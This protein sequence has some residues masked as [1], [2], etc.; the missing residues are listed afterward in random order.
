[1]QLTGKHEIPATAKRIWD[2]MM[3]PEVL[4]RITPG[5][6]HLELVEEDS[7]KAIAEIKIGPVGGAF[8]GTLKV[9]DKNEPHSFSLIVQQNSRLGTASAVVAMALNT[10]ETGTTEVSF[11]G[12]VRLSGMMATMGQRVLSPVAHMLS[13]QF[14]EALKLEV[15]GSV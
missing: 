3:D 10:L 14:F 6:T 11:L 9:A 7:Y 8:T 15:E 12:D 1:M 4:T 2:L 5:I 13:G